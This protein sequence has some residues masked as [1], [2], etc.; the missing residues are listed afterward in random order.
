MESV[1][2]K[3]NQIMSAAHLRYYGGVFYLEIILRNLLVST[4]V[5]GKAKYQLWS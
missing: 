3:Q 1:Q 5:M 2:I 4:V